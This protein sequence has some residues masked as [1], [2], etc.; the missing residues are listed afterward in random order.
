[1]CN[2]FLILFF[3]TEVLKDEAPGPFG[4]LIFQAKLKHKDDVRKG[5]MKRERNV[6][7]IYNTIFWQVAKIVGEIKK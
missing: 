6:F 2:R 5:A 4:R 1:M 7:D 3:I